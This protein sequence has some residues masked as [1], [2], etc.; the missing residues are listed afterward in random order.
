MDSEENTQEVVND[1][2]AVA[3]QLLML[4]IKSLV[5]G[6]QKSKPQAR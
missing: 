4:V 3:G 5:C 1:N 6:T 2:R